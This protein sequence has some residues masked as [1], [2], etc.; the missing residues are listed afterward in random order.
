MSRM[1]DTSESA[2]DDQN[3]LII[4]RPD[5]IVQRGLLLQPATYASVCFLMLL[6]FPVLPLAVKLV[7]IAG[8]LLTLRRW[9]AVMI[10]LLVQVDLF[11]RE[12]RAFSALRGSDGLILAFVTMSV[13]MFVSRQ[14]LLLMHL[15]GFSFRDLIRRWSDST[16]VNRTSEN[17]SAVSGHSE[18]LPDS[19]TTKSSTFS[20]ETLIDNVNASTRSIVPLVP[21]ALRALAMLLVCVTVSRYLLS[22]VPSNYELTGQLRDLVNNDPTLSSAA[23]LLM[24][25]LA[26]WVVIREISW[27]QLTPEQARVYLRSELLRET[28]SDVRMFVIRRIRRRQKRVLATSKSQEPPGSKPGKS[29]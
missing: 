21:A 2:I 10:L 15:A 17:R 24:L 3:N 26:V 22:C 4:D 14:R 23:M 5:Q 12:G 28:Y 9:G 29:T 6:L 27:R 20:A 1:M 13:L 16:V 8:V 7:L 11:L 18:K 19:G 25:I